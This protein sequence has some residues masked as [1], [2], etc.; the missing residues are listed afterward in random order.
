MAHTKVVRA[1]QHAAES[2]ATTIDQI[3]ISLGCG[4]EHARAVEVF[5]YQCLGCLGAEVTQEHHQCIATGR[6]HFG[7]GLEHVM[8]VL[9]GCLAIKQF[10]LVSFYNV[11]APFSRQCDRKTVTTDGNNAQLDRWDVRTYHI[12]SSYSLD[13]LCFQR[14]R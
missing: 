2:V 13:C 5:C 9:H 11:F 1:V 10:A 12:N 7:N 8:L 3:A 6:F 4:H 14:Q